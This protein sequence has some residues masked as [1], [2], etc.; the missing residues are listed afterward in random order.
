MPGNM[1]HD[2]PQ[3]TQGEV[4]QDLLT[5][6]GLR[7]ERIVSHGQASPEGFWYDQDWDEWVLVLQGLAVLELEGRTEPLVLSAGDYCWL[8]AHCRHRV[9]ATAPQEPTIWLAVHHEAVG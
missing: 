1:F 3:A 5:M 4:F 7:I 9:V 6:P 2:L 8:P